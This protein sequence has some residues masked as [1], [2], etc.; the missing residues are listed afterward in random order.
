MN[1]TLHVIDSSGPGEPMLPALIHCLRR[2]RAPVALL[3]GSDGAS[4]TRR[5]GLHDFHHIAPPLGRAEL[6][7]PA[8]RT[9]ARRLNARDIVAWSPA[10]AAG[11]RWT[12]RN[13]R[14]VIA[15]RPER[16][17]PFAQRAVRSLISR[18]A[19]A[20]VGRDSAEAWSNTPNTGCA[21]A[22]EAP[23]AVADAAS[24]RRDARLGWGADDQLVIGLVDADGAGGPTVDGY[25]VSF[26]VGCLAMTGRDM[27]AIAPRG[28]RGLERG[29]RQMERHGDR[30]RVIPERRPA[31]R[32]IPGCDV[33]MAFGPGGVAHAWAAQT[34]AT[35]LPVGPEWETP[36]GQTT[37]RRPRE[38]AA[39]ILKA[40][41]ARADRARNDGRPARGD[42][43]SA[44]TQLRNGAPIRAERRSAPAMSPA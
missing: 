8:L 13:V 30:W 7:G 32:W 16:C 41:D 42:I 18:G 36:V 20:F 15:T 23:C 44:L 27:L 39:A 1:A 19:V 35:L 21:V 17:G 28:A 34:G 24:A 4:E 22:E 2:E 33:L 5:A 29:K 31:W 11:A 38:A 3:D 26:V 14:A 43:A 12:G 10:A 37:T 25:F 40:L 9:L 6:A